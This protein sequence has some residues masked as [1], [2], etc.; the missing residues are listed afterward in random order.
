[1]ALTTAQK[2]SV[3]EIIDT[4][5]TGNVDEMY[6]KFGLSALTYEVSDDGKVQ[7]KVL[8]RL[9]KLTSEEEEFLLIYVDKWQDLGTQPWALD[10]GTAG[11]DGFAYAPQNEREII[12]QRVKVL[13]PV[14]HYWENVEQ[15][16][17]GQTMS[18]STI[19]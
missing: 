16:A 14:R 5:Y 19:R 6:G 8:D 2:I 17:A 9:T 7:L 12:R 1:M 4:P 10:G 13:I 18:V 15:S 11:V 3:F